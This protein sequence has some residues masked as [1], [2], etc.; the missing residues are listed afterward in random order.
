LKSKSKFLTFIFSF[1]PGLSH[2]YLGFAARGAMFIAA[3]GGVAIAIAGLNEIFPTNDVNFLLILIP[4]IWF[5]AMVD[6]MIL[7]DKINLYADNPSLMRDGGNVL[8]NYG[9]LTKQNKKLIAM[10]LSVIPGVGHLYLG[11]QRQGIELMASFFLV[12]F[13][14]DWL[15][16]SGFIILAPIIWF[17]SLFDVMH[18]VTGER[19]M[20]DDDIFA[21]KWFNNGESFIKNKSKFIGYLLIIAGLLAI[22]NRIV[23]PLIGVYFS[24]EFISDI[25]T[26]IVALLLILGGVKLIADSKKKLIG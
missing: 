22:F 9:E 16:F 20:K 3:I 19:E 25:Q 4:I 7:V 14:T 1:V 5:A 6:S 21:L 17:Y 13:L 24:Q 11:L 23:L 12:F 2:I 15:R 10:F 18:K 8:P 26:G